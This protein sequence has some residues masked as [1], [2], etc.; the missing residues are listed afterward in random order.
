MRNDVGKLRQL[1]YRVDSGTGPTGGYRLGSG[2]AMPPLLLDD[3]E[4]VAVVVGLRAAAAGTVTGIGDASLNALTKLERTLVAAE[5]STSTS[6]RV[7][8]RE[9]GT[10]ELITGTDSL[11]D[12]T[13]YLNMFD[14]PFTVLD[15]PELREFLR[16]LAD[17][18]REAT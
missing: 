18:Y 17:R 6:G 4:A 14:V 15:P 12:L 3:D 9:D 16:K 1:G 8:P 10:C 7:L 5:L 2:T 11:A 13:A